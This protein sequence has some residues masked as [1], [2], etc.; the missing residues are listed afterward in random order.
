MMPWI[1]NIAKAV[2][3]FIPISVADGL[4]DVLGINE[5]MDDFKGRNAGTSK[6]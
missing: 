1:C 3:V 4:S 6:K 5:S 2:N